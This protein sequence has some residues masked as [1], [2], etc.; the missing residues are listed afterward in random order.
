MIASTPPR[1]GLVAVLACS[2]LSRALIDD[3]DGSDT[4]QRAILCPG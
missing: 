1:A 4:G 2:L 3:K